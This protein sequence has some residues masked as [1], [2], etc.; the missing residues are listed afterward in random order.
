MG[1]KGVIRSIET[2]HRRAQRELEKQQKQKERMEEIERAAYEFEVYQNSIEVLITIHEDCSEVWDWESL[3]AA[4]PPEEPTKSDAH[5]HKARVVQ[6]DYKPTLMD[7]ITKRVDKKHQLFETGVIRAKRKDDEAYQRALADY[8]QAVSEWEYI[9]GLA[10]KILAKDIDSYQEAISQ[11]GPFREISQ[12]GSSIS[13]EVVDSGFATATLCVH[14]ESV[15]PNKRVSLLKSGKLSIKDM[16][17][18]KFYELYQDFIC[19]AV[20]RVARELFALL[21]LEM[22]IIT[23]TGDILNTKTG[24]IEEQPILSVAVP[25][26]TAD[27]LNFATIDPSDAMVNFVH[28]MKFQKTKGF[29]PIEPIKTADVDLSDQIADADSFYFPPAL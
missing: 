2:A 3:Q 18:T 25:R 4:D 26:K 5:E 20:L 1:Y 23:A 7:K 22:T 8:K 12:L 24:H 27:M 21:P 6:E 14:S 13:F 28:N 19:S 17:K 16:P 9:R 11:V 15:V 29:L 10:G